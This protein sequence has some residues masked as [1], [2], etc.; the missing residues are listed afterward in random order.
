VTAGISA[1]PGQPGGPVG[2]G[3]DGHDGHDGTDGTHGRSVQA[4]DTMNVDRGTMDDPERELAIAFA[5]GA[6]WALRAVY[7]RYGGLIYRIAQRSLTNRSDAEEVTQTTFI[8]AWQGR[9]TFDPARG[10]IGG[11]LVAIVRRRVIDRLRTVQREQRATEAAA[12]ASGWADRLEGVEHAD[13]VVASVVVTDG[14][15][16]LPETQRRVLQM[17]F[18]ED[19]THQQIA[20]MT[21]LPLGTVKSH[22]RRGL[23]ELRRRLEVAGVEPV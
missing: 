11:W 1:L 5:E 16:E 20:S 8:S 10:T 15:A 14:L 22:V 2:S 7:D 21:G 6:D 3:H 12:R 13:Q 18:Y 17:A 23:T 19:L 9:A 4:G